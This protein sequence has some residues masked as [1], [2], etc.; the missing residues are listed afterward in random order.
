MQM[1]LTEYED[2]MNPGG[3]ITASADADVD[4]IIKSLEM[5]TEFFIDFFLHEELVWDVP[6]FHK[7]LFGKIKDLTIKRLILAV[8]RDHA[9]TTLAKLGVVWYFLFSQYRFCVY[10]SNT[11]PFAKN[12]CRDIMNFMKS[13]NF[14]KV[15]GHINI[16]KESE[17][18][19]LW[20]FTLQLP[21]GRSKRCILRASGAGNQMRGINVDNKR[22]EVAVIDDLEDREN[23]KTE[24]QQTAMIEWFMGTFYKALAKNTKMMYLGNMVAKNCLLEQLCASPN[25]TTFLYG[26][27]VPDESGK[28]VSLWP[29]RWPLAEL[30]ED[31]KE[32]QR[33]GLLH[34]WMAEM[35]NRPGAGSKGFQA[36]QIKYDTL[37][38]LD[39]CTATF[40]T[41]DPAFTKNRTS[42]RTAIVVHALRENRPPI[43]VDYVHEKLTEGEIF[44]NALMLALRWNAWVWGVESVAAQRVLI[45]LFKVLATQQL[46][47]G[48]E[49]V[50]ILGSNASKLARISAWVGLMEQDG[51][52]VPYGD[53]SI[54]T[55]LL[56]Y[57][58][59]TQNNDDD[60]IDGCSMGLPMLENY[61]HLIMSQFAMQET[62]NVTQGQSEIC[63][64]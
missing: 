36:K 8:P 29:D 12:A 58:K 40:L 39:A 33:L 14:I 20:I 57:D 51:Y 16:E 60:L 23:V 1:E 47:I 6:K 53:L 56:G 28:M 7:D 49:V 27:L 26:C 3:S 24:H 54:T 43:I 61:L 48:L 42:D 45:T 10:L 32:Y 9:K 52:N 55:Q 63:N 37:P 15:F 4:S 35:M 22:P 31:F 64:V 30:I 5:D 59:T 46:I 41:V 44:E 25:W 13:D 34:I 62:R 19:G 2:S 18:E 38:V 50:G 21:G 17:T 11:A